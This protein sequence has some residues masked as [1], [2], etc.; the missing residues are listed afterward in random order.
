MWLRGVAQA[1]VASFVGNNYDISEGCGVCL[2]ADD[3]IVKSF[4]IGL[5]SDG[6]RAIKVCN[7]GHID[8]NIAYTNVSIQVLWLK[9][10]DL[11]VTTMVQVKIVTHG[12]HSRTIL[13]KGFKQLI[14]LEKSS[15]M[16]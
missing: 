4:N 5:A 9:A 2:I 16:N 10:I 15:R 3:D 6:C 12:F 14:E 11:P 7:T 8:D 1:K 13:L